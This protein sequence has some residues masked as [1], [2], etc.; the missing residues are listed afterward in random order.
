MVWL[1]NERQLALF[2]VGTIV[3]R[4]ATSGISNRSR[5]GFE[6]VRDLSSGLVE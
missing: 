1:A 6:P 4:F 5:A 2:P 3:K